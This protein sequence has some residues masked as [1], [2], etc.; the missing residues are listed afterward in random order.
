MLHIFLKQ[1][2]KTILVLHKAS[3][4]ASRQCRR[5][6]YHSDKNRVVILSVIKLGIMLG[7]KRVLFPASSPELVID[8]ITRRG[9]KRSH[10]VDRQEPLQPA[11]SRSRWEKL[12]GNG[13]SIVDGGILTCVSGKSRNEATLQKLKRESKRRKAQRTAKATGSVLMNLENNGRR[14]NYTH[15]QSLVTTVRNL[16]L[17]GLSMDSL[18]SAAPRRKR[19]FACRS[20]ISIQSSPSKMVSKNQF[21]KNTGLALQTIVPTKRVKWSYKS[22]ANVDSLIACSEKQSESVA[23]SF[24]PQEASVVETVSL[25]SAN[26]VTKK[27]MHKE[28]LKSLRQQQQQ[29]Q[30]QSN[31]QRR[32]ILRNRENSSQ[33]QKGTISKEISP[34]LSCTLANV[35]HVTEMST[36]NMRGLVSPNGPKLVTTETDTIAISSSDKTWTEKGN[37][38]ATPVPFTSVP[39]VPLVASSGQ[40]GESRHANALVSS[41]ELVVSH[42]PKLCHENSIPIMSQE[43]EL[44]HMIPPQGINDNHGLPMNELYLCHRRG[45]AP[46]VSGLTCENHRATTKKGMPN[47][48]ASKHIRGGNENPVYSTESNVK[49]LGNVKAHN[50]EGSTNTAETNWGSGPR[51]RISLRLSDRATTIKSQDVSI[52][53][54]REGK[55]EISAR[56]KEKEKVKGERRNVTCQLRR[57]NRQRSRPLRFG[58]SPKKEDQIYGDSAAGNSPYFVSKRPIGSKVRKQF[59]N[60]GWFDGTVVSFDAQNGLYKIKCE[61]GTDDVDGAELEAIHKNVTQEFETTHSSFPHGGKSYCDERFHDIKWRVPENGKACVN[62]MEGKSGL[63][64]VQSDCETDDVFNAAQMLNATP[65]ANMTIVRAFSHEKNPLSNGKDDI[66]D[67][68][69]LQVQQNI[70]ASNIS[71]LI[72]TEVDTQT[73]S[74]VSKRAR[75][76]PQHYGKYEN[77]VIDL[78]RPNLSKKKAELK[79]E[80]SNFLKQEKKRVRISIET[81]MDNPIW[82]SFELDSLIKAHKDNDPRSSTFWEDISH[83]VMTK[84]PEECIERWYS[85]AKTPVA[86]K[87]AFKHVRALSNSQIGGSQIIVADDDIFNATPMRGMHASSDLRHDSLWVSIQQLEHMSNFAGS[88]I[89]ASRPPD[90]NNSEPSENFTQRVYPQGY[91]TYIRNISRK[92]RQKHQRTK[93]MKTET[94]FKS[95]KPLRE[96]ANNG[97]IDMNCQLSPGGT[98]HLRTTSDSSSNLFLKYYE[99]D[100]GSKDYD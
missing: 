56:L 57:S 51:R 61:H 30:Q 97:D 2:Q 20:K 27:S 18:A 67:G 100:C 28:G 53:E 49:P 66:F 89:K 47:K 99:H 9:P 39:S 10:P 40:I 62:E 43:L 73:S 94:F 4:P 75:K 25:T 19:D 72:P 92:V 79:R 16:R 77:E 63:R 26:D 13:V 91:K 83:L 15:K 34:T 93:K 1:R 82:N 22:E 12:H 74:A 45:L 85:L 17:K 36:A 86:K 88:A 38:K 95:S 41:H 32:R 35:K 58:T 87:P 69:P 31:T 3:T 33:S 76:L 70:N 54:L 55:R 23:T 50:T 46:S 60:L 29:Q 14:C 71:V 42:Q 65:R 21:T 78:S 68:R 90:S 80:V 37:L 24:A 11:A 84:S 8:L 5:C 52:N 44:F 96:R 48:Q 59:G 6:C 64:Q 98:L 7:L 81:S